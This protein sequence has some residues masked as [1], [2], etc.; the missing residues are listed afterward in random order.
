MAS[1]NSDVSVGQNQGN[2]AMYPAGYCM[3]QGHD[4]THSLIGTLSSRTTGTNATTR[5]ATT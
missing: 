5:A 2:S 3:P 1:G 4:E